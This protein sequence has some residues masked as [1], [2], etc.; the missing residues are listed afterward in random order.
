MAEAEGFR[1]KFTG[2][3]FKG[4]AFRK[5]PIPGDE[6]H[7]ILEFFHGHRETV[8]RKEYNEWPEKDCVSK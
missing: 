7:W 8:T 2:G 1:K 4:L 6:E 3:P 5:L